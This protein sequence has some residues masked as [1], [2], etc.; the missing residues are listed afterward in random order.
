MDSKKDELPGSPHPRVHYTWFQLLIL[1][2]LCI[3]NAAH[4][5]LTRYSRGVLREKY[6][7][8]E[9]VIFSEAIKIVFSS[10]MYISEQKQEDK[11]RRDQGV[12]RGDFS[13]VAILRRLV[14]LLLHNSLHVVVL[15]I[16]YACGNLLAY[17]ALARV[18]AAQYAVISQLKIL[19]TATFS[20]YFLGRHLTMSKWRALLL[21]VI[22]CI[23]VASPSYM[24]RCED[25]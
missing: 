4:G 20:V 24:A 1:A 19:T 21:L 8:T 3:H 22:G 14:A 5:L 7:T 6:N 25:D 15:V 12:G 13:V 9:L 17:Y 23:L 10:F 16:L 2:L 11:D 18:D